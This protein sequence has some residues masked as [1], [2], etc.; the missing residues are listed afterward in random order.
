M[1][2]YAHLLLTLKTVTEEVDGFT[3][4]GMATTPEPDLLRDEIDP[5]GAQF[6]LPMPLLWQHKRGEVV[7]RVEAAKVTDAGIQF[8]AFLPY[9]K[10]AGR[11]KDRVDEAI[12]SIKHRLVSAVSIGFKENPSKTERA[13]SGGLRFKEW[14]W[15]ELSLVDIPM[16]AAATILTARTA[17]PP[18][19]STLLSPPSRATPMPAVAG[20]VMERLS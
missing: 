11:L 19:L 14:R 9:V 15:L 8:R 17:A 5:R 4:T 12:Q 3:I 13:K 18:R 10:E 16:N 20:P 1:E 2:R 7:G 6:T